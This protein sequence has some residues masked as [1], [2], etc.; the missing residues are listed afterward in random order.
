M[1]SFAL[2]STQRRAETTELRG[3]VARRRLR[4]HL[5]RVQRLIFELNVINGA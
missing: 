5:Q 1:A 4:V 2:R 3:I